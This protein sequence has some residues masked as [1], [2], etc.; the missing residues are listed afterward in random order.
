MKTAFPAIVD[1]SF[2]A[3]MESLLDMVEEGSVQW[4]T[5]VRNFYPDLEKSIK[6]AEKALEKLRFRT[7]RQMLSVMYVEE[8]WL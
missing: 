5:V 1:S 7:N 4:K 8:I 3:N 6:N 2:T